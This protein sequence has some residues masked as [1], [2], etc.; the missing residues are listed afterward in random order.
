MAVDIWTKLWGWIW[1]LKTYDWKF[2]SIYRSLPRSS[3]CYDLLYSDSN[4]E[5]SPLRRRLAS[6]HITIQPSCGQYDWTIRNI[7]HHYHC[8]FPSEASELA[9]LSLCSADK[10]VHL[11][12]DLFQCRVSHRRNCQVPLSK[13]AGFRIY[14]IVKPIYDILVCRNRYL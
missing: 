11:W 9:H 7:L 12:K 8:F 13:I 5:T 14:G 6:Y 2:G 10:D 4:P 1:S 3:C